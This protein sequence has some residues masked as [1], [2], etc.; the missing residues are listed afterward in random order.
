MGNDSSELKEVLDVVSE[1]VPQLIKDVM[2][3]VFSKEAGQGSGAAV[4]SYYK[5]LMDAGIP[6]EAALEMAKEYAKMQANMLNFKSFHYDG[7]SKHGK[8]VIN[9]DEINEPEDAE[10]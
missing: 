4:G 5:E 9:E 8:V 3:S 10:A 2:G 7:D 6:Q 1:K